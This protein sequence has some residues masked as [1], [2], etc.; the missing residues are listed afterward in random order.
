MIL[1]TGD[2]HFGHESVIRFDNRPFSSVAEMDRMLIELWNKKVGTNDVV[3]VNGD[4]AYRNSK[5]PEWYLEQL[6]GKKYLIIGNH[7]TKM[8]KNSKAMAYFEGVDKM[9]HVVDDGKHVCVCHY[10]MVEWY[11][12]YRGNYHVY[13]HIH[14]SVN[15]SYQIMR[16][17]DNAFNCGVPINGYVPVTFWEMVENNKIFDSENKATVL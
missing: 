12:M 2:L 1:Y 4:F 11:G 8:L 14:R 16:T 13:A 9:M 6:K 17:L 10:P 7:D 5:P 15:R 3:Y